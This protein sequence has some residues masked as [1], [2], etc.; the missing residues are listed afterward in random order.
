[1]E[2]KQSNSVEKK[3]SF[4][5]NVLYLAIIIGLLY[6]VFKKLIP[7]VSPFVYAFIIAFFLR[8][9]ARAIA[10]KLKVP[11]TPVSI[12]LILI[13][14]GVVGFLV[15]VLA[16]KTAAKVQ[17][18]FIDLPEIYKN[19]IEPVLFSLSDFFENSIK[20]ID[21]SFEEIVNNNFNQI[22]AQL[23]DMVS[24]VSL[25]FVGTLSN[26]LS[27]IP[28]LFI[29]TLI[30]IIS[31]F[32][33]AIDFDKIS[34]FIHRQLNDRGREVFAEI[35]DYMVN[36]LFVIIKSY[37]LIMSITFIELFLGLSLIKV[38]NALIIS[39]VIAVFDILPVVGT[40]GI[41]IP[42]GVITL[43]RGDITLGISLLILYLII[44]V[45][46]NILEPKIVGSQLGLH[47]V[48]TLM[49]M[50]VGVSLAGGL[51]LFGFPILLSL[52]CHLNKTG[53]IKLFQQEEAEVETGQTK[54]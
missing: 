23:G 12:V 30:M 19:Q 11:R 9:P 47:P 52:L 6:L 2:K 46:R 8:K 25:N 28:A 1:M 42:W 51:G 38:D 45:I 26:K 49:S 21:P 5:I 24:K 50:F 31:T 43:I 34:G 7:L 35:K 18:I 16:I 33:I 17:Q 13:F 4:I 27:F 39:L 37:I 10:E 41:V 15:G 53:T 29:K 22:V 36:T 32:F 40:G 54:S 14:Y 3:R 48:I 20:Q 44:T